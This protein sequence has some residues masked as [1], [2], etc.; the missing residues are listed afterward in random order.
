MPWRHGRRCTETHWL[1]ASEIR[2]LDIRINNID[3]TYKNIRVVSLYYKT[4]HDT[5]DITIIYEGSAGSSL[6]ITDT[7]SISLGSIT[8]QEFSAIK[9]NF[10]CRYMKMPKTQEENVTLTY[11]TK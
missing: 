10:I 9:D 4:L 11:L 8:Y 6:N 1:R 5:P 2:L 7:G 3:Q